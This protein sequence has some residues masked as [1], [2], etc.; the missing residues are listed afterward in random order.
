ME[1]GYLSMKSSVY[2]ESEG[3]ILLNNEIKGT[4]LQLF[5]HPCCKDNT[6][7]WFSI[8]FYEMKST[9]PAWLAYCSCSIHVIF[10]NIFA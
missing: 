4:S 9:E 8:L 1:I 5:V 3:S 2:I 6:T 10:R 7:E